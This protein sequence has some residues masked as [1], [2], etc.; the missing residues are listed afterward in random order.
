MWHAA[1]RDYLEVVERVCPTL[2]AGEAE[3][4]VGALHAFVTLSCEVL[5]FTTITYNAC[6]EWLV[7]WAIE[8][9]SGVERD[10]VVGE[11]VVCVLL[12]TVAAVTQI[13]VRARVALM[14]NS[15]YGILT[16]AI[17]CDSVVYNVALNSPWR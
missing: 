16:T 12:E 15:L 14:P 13:K 2:E 8:S 4:I 7:V 9:G 17:A 1:G 5:S 3:I 11:S 6:V 10:L